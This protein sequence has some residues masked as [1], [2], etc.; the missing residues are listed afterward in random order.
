MNSLSIT[1]FR[2][3]REKR[4][5]NER[6][7]KKRLQRLQKEKEKEEEKARKEREELWSYDCLHKN[8]ELMTTNQDDGNDS[9]DFM[10][11]N[12]EGWHIST[13]SWCCVRFLS[14]WMH[15]L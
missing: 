3:E 10:W 13:M 4:D 11:E 1:D 8:A 14:A 2:L 12:T 9:D 15:Y 5:A 6:E 7:D